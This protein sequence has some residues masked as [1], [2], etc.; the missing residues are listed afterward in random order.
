[1][2]CTTNTGRPKLLTIDTSICGGCFYLFG[3]QFNPF[4]RDQYLI[5]K[6]PFVFT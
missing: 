6:S 5:L 3:I 2:Q 4:E 1:M